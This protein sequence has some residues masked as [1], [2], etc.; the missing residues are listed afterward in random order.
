MSVTA[1]V[2]QVQPLNFQPTILVVD[3]SEI[4]LEMTEEMLRSTGH[5][6][7]TCDTPIGV[8][9]VAV[10]EQPDLVLVDLEMASLG[11]DRVVAAL[12]R[13]GRTA[14]IP[15]VIHSD[16]SVAELEAAVL[17]SGADGYIR[18][19]SDARLLSRTIRQY[20]GE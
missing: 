8:T 18:K 11:G 14:H 4:V 16:R 10:R 5:D 7:R 6:V 20:L 17:K 3:D 12:K 2:K 1:M 13:G 19:T 15:V 9:L